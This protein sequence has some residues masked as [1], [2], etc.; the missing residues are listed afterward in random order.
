M[1]E[2]ITA[3]FADPVRQTGRRRSFHGEPDV[4]PPAAGGFSQLG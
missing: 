2:T 4:S 1:V 3:A